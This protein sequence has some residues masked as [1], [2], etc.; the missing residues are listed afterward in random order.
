MNSFFSQTPNSI[1]PLL[2]NIA[3]FLPPS[4][5]SI[6]HANEIRGYLYSGLIFGKLDA[7]LGN[8]SDLEVV[9]RRQKKITE[10]NVDNDCNKD[11]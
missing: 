4:Y 11:I 8:G 5:N 3:A 6:A 2:K 9:L 10:D 1:S 7:L